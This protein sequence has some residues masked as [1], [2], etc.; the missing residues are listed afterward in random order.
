MK[1]VI[2][3]LAEITNDRKTNFNHQYTKA[4]E[5]TGGIPLL[6][7]YTDNGESMDAFVDFCDGFLFTGGA[8][9]DPA[10]YGEAV[11]ERCGEIQSFRD[12][13]EF[14]MLKKILATGKPVMA[15]CR[16]EQLVNV[17]LGGTLYQ[18]IPTE[19]PSD[20]SH[21]QKEPRFSPSHS[22]N[23]LDNTPL[24][25]LMGT[26]RIAANT[27]HHQAIK[28]LGEGLT[29]MARADDGT[30]EAVYLRGY[31]YLR[32]YQWHPERLFETDPHNRRI[33]EDFIV[34]SSIKV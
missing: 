2:A 8:D 24:R 5:S 1:P 19:A 33:F 25:T 31:N 20:I 27:F 26:D 17:A 22:V 6:L 11:S 28:K 4:I 21:S 12:A 29:V 23:I 9:I 10:R 16:G 7:P 32:A 13:F 30:V 34:A 3:I 18:D 14:E 15:I